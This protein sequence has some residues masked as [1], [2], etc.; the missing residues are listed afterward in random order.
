MFDAPVDAWYV[1]LGLGAVSVAVAGTA[2]ALPTAAPPTPGPV[3]DTIDSV[4]SS[5]YRGRA[6]VAVTADR[7]RLTRRAIALRTDG[8]TART[9][10]AF[11]PVT[12]AWS[13]ELQRLV[14]GAKPGSVFRTAE[15]FQAALERAR[16]ASRRWRRAPESLTV[17]RVRWGEV[18][19]TLVG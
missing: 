11:G 5:Q 13:A 16:G 18:N 4:A 8:G 2:L 14:H 7:L 1:W 9:R 19:A 17:R 6:T 3:A 10:F 15:G 12:P